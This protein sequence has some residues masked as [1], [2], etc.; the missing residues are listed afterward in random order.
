MSFLKGWRTIILNVAAGITSTGAV[1][2]AA[3]ASDT[4]DL[5]TVLGQFI[6]P[7]RAALAVS[8]LT[9]ANVLLRIDTTGPVGTKD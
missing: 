5:N 6:T 7:T 9:L 4:A 2:V 3:L 1:L 8:G